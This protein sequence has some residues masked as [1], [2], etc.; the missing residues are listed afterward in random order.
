[1]TDNHDIFPG[2]PPEP[3][4]NYWQY[5]KALNGWWY[6]LTPTEQKV[7]DY[8]LRHTW[9]FK[10]SADSISLS[11]FKN[12]ITKLDGT[13]FDRGTGIRDERTIRKALDG[14]IQKG[15]ITIERV[16]GKETIF[17][18]KIDPSQ[19]MQLRTKNDSSLPSKDDTTHP[20]QEMTPTIKNT[21]INNINSN[22]VSQVNDKKAYKDEIT[23]LIG[24][25]SMKLKVKFPNYG[26]QARFTKSILDSGFTADDI[27][28]SIEQMCA[29]QWWQEH[30]FDMKNVADEIPKLMTRTIKT[31]G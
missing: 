11:Q 23:S 4:T 3:V 16:S 25:L 14:L 10:K 31:K 30:S 12:G 19:E 1:M 6:N 24:Y 17:R 21:P 18:L 20:S 8:I 28:W 15:F 2:F 26:K 27:R 29:N 13:V 5:P 22:P 9:G 7:L